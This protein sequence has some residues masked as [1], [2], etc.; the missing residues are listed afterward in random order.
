MRWAGHFAR[1]FFKRAP[2]A[3]PATLAYLYAMRSYERK[4]E[5]GTVQQ[6]HVGSDGHEP[7]STDREQIQE[8]TDNIKQHGID[9][10]KVINEAECP[11]NSSGDV[12]GFF[13]L[14]PLAL[15]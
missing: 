6:L 11:Y 13:D 3:R 9:N 12:N 8:L 1:T 4:L 7:K 5:D 2:F 15:D 10:C 14:L